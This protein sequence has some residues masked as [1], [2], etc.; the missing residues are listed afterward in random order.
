MHRIYQVRNGTEYRAQAM[1]HNPLPALHANT[2][3]NMSFEA[4]LYA[5]ENNLHNFQSSAIG[6]I[7]VYSFLPT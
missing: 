4:S 3:S 6:V 1:T 2:K 5:S 7:T